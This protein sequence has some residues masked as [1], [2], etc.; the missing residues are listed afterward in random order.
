MSWRRVA[1][2]GLLLANILVL[3]SLVWGKRG[4]LAYWEQQSR[5]ATLV[6][7]LADLDTKGVLLSAEIREWLSNE[8]YRQQVVREKM[9]YVGDNEI[10]YVFP[11]EQDQSTADLRSEP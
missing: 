5:H 4:F 9:N 1:F 2:W 6:H 3:V 10:L 8:Q 11:V 7:K